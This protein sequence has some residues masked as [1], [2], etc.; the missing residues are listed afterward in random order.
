MLGQV[1][2]ASIAAIETRG[3]TKQYGRGPKGRVS[4]DRLDLTIQQGEVYALLG[5]NGAGKT[6]TIGMLTTLLPP[7]AGY[8]KIC[9]YDGRKQSEKTKGLFGV[10]SQDVA[11]YQELTV[12]ENLKFLADLYGIQDKKAQE[13]IDKLL[14]RFDL[15]DRINEPAD[16]LSGGM[17]R[18]LAIA[19]AMVNSPRVLFMDEPTVGLDPGSR[20]QIWATIKELK[21]LGVTILLTTHYLE[22]AELLADRIGIIK[23][24]KLLIEGTVHQLT[25]KIRGMRGISV[26][27]DARLFVEAGERARLD[28]ALERLKASH[29]EALSAPEAIRVDELRNTVYFLSAHANQAGEAESFFKAIYQ[30][31]EDENLEFVRVAFGEPNLEDVFM[32]VIK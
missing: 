15:A 26:K 29:P 24:G 2:P 19:C 18:R 32:A 30:W 20:R 17:Q 22:E 10:V 3:L 4:V 14:A 6:T 1:D 7:T 12:W 8:F 31:L 28:A 5:D 11:V 27:F 23:G 16:R 21:T 25:Q 9:G 13:R